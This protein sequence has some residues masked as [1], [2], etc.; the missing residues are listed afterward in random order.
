MT[1]RT[2]AFTAEQAAEYVGLPLAR[3]RRLIAQG[4][5]PAPVNLLGREYH[6]QFLLDCWLYDPTS[7]RA[8][9]DL[10]GGPDGVISSE[11]AMRRLFGAREESGDD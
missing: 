7:N 3:Y 8:M 5:L 6:D 2:T 9:V 4:V 10:S 1:E 11:G